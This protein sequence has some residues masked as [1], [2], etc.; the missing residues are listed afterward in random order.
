MLT[1]DH[2]YHFDTLQVHGGQQP[3]P[4]TNAR[5]VPIYASTSFVFNDYQHSID[6]CNLRAK[7]HLYS[8]YGCV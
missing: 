8:R 6:L 3:D 5:A 4:S 2:K 1:S 7:G